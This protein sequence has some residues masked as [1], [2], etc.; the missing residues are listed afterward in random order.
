MGGGRE[1]AQPRRRYDGAFKSMVV[2]EA[3]CGQKVVAELACEYGVHPNQIT[4]VEKAFYGPAPRD[5]FDEL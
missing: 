2:L 1:M 4:K 5:L 3:I